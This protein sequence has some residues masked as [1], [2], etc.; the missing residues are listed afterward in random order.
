MVLDQFQS[1]LQGSKHVGAFE[2]VKKA[3]QQT[4]RHAQ[5]ADARNNTPLPYLSSV[6][7]AVGITSHSDDNNSPWI[8]KAQRLNTCADS[9]HNEA[10]QFLQ[11]LKAPQAQYDESK[12]EEHADT[13]APLSGH[14]QQSYQLLVQRLLS[15]AGAQLNINTSRADSRRLTESSTRKQDPAQDPAQQPRQ[16]PLQVQKLE[17]ADGLHQASAHDLHQVSAHDLQTGKL[18]AQVLQQSTC[19]LHAKALH[20]E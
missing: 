16:A 12:P 14:A 18:A 1:F 4:A 6:H 7:D 20:L 11:R 2:P 15:P 17:Q 10:V 5:H 19:I 9:L 3:E 13:A 8:L